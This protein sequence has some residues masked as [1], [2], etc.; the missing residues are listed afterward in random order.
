MKAEVE[1][2]KGKIL[3]LERI[4]PKETDNRDHFASQDLGQKEKLATDR[5]LKHLE[6][7]LQRLLT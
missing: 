5:R 4:K 2:V 6:V 1:W 3:S 7:E